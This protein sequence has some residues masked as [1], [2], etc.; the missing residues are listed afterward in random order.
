MKTAEVQFNKT[1][2]IKKFNISDYNPAM[3]AKKKQLQLCSFQ[4]ILKE[5][6]KLFFP[7]GWIGAFWGAFIWVLYY[8][9]HSF[10]PSSI[11]KLAMIHVFLM[12][13]IMGFLMTAIPKFTASFPTQKYEFF[14]GFIG[15]LLLILEMFLGGATPNSLFIWSSTF[16]CLTTLIFFVGRRFKYA[17]QSPPPSFVFI[18]VG[19]II[20]WLFSSLEFIRILFNLHYFLTWNLILTQWIYSQFVFALILG[21]GSKLIPAICGW[22]KMQSPQEL[23]SLKKRFIGYA[24]LFIFTFIIKNF[25][26]SDNSVYSFLKF[27]FGD[28]LRILLITFILLKEWNLIRLPAQRTKLS[29]GLWT[30]SWSLLV[31]E[32]CALLF[33]Q[34]KIH[35]EHFTLISGFCLMTLTVATRV[36]LAHGGYDLTQ[37]KKSK[38]I[39]ATLILILI[40][41]LTRVFAGF[42]PAIYESHLFY[43]SITL[44]IALITWGSL[45][46]PKFI[47]RA[48]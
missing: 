9:T 31:G 23:L 3:D 19:I 14:F 8:M 38:R 28:V 17:K 11:H 42:S 37:E 47:F 20:T 21:V 27:T 45:M 46:L 40:A 15:V 29:W 1:I 43:A 16:V 36:G 44:I 12:C 33:P 13:Y 18:G 5:P 24:G 34:Y 22:G 48:K 7:L 26:I 32:W 2:P 10:Y 6:Y 41:A 35:F 39:F 25:T 30:S 4:S